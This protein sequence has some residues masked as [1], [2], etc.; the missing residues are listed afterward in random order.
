[1]TANV[2]TPVIVDL[3]PLYASGDASAET[4]ALVE[5]FLRAHPELKRQLSEDVPLGEAPAPLPPD[6]QA[7]AFALTRRKLRGIP[8]LLFVAMLFSMMAFG[9]IVSDTSWDVSPRTFIVTASIAAAFWIAFIVSLWLRRAT[10]LI[11]PGPR[12]RR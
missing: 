7:K 10:I 6:H 11:A 5:E 12:R 9:R 8:W 2:T 4:A 1:M 3:W